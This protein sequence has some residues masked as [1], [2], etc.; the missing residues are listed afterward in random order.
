MSTTPAGT[1]PDRLYDLIPTVYRLRDADEGWP[2]RAL[3]RVLAEQAS[4]LEDDITGLYRNWF[5]ET[6]DAWVLPYIGALVGFA[7]AGGAGA[8][9]ARAEVANTIRLRRRKGTL[10][11]LA[12]IAE[13]V[14]GWPARAVE[15]YRALALAQHLDHLHA[16]R[17]RTVELRNVDA[18]AAIGTAFD[19]TARNVDVRRSNSTH[20]AGVGNIPDVGV[21]LWRLAARTVSRAPAYCYEEESPNC[22]LF[23]ALG[24]DTP[25]FV[26]PK[27][28]GADPPLPVPITR[29]AFERRETDQKRGTIGSGIQHYYGPHGSLMIWLGAPPKPV[30]ADRIVAADLRDW[31]YRPRPGQV[32]VDPERG[33]IM[34]PPNEVRRQPVT[35]SYAAGAVAAIGGG[36]YPR[37]LDAPAGA[38][39]LRVGPEAEFARLTD[40]LAAWRAAAPPAAVIEIQDSGVY[41]EPFAV[42]LQSGQGLQLRAAARV[43]P[44]LRLLDWQ[45]DRPDLLSVAGER[46]SWF[47]LDGMT[48]T[49]RGMEISGDVA[50]VVIRHSTLV[51]GWGLTCLCDP[52]RPAEPSILVLGRPRCLTL[53]HAIIGAIRVERDQAVDEPLLLR[54]QDSVIDA[55]A[56]TR[57]ALGASD[58]LCADARLTLARCTVVGEVQTHMIDLAEDSILDGHVLAC[59]RQVGCVRFCAL[60][61]GSR[62]PR[63]YACTEKAPDF[64]STRYGL[65]AY[66]RLSR[67]C[68]P[69]IGSGAESGSE[70]GVYHDLMQPQRLA[71]VRQ[72]LAEYGPA[73]TSTGVILTT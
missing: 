23:S 48:V 20:A 50:G 14:G 28:G 54:A 65:P 6:C 8:P 41:A 64:D 56:P 2:L 70:M 73:S 38:M 13:A 58:R 47:K 1:G 44:V 45:G 62:T 61:A 40:A 72:R 25:L 43:R 57:A 60:P 19:R 12:A 39:L 55:T 63:R 67:A 49:G 59:R 22:Y 27:A 68:P 69:E 3:L 21:Y 30:P 34:F 51:P 26:D 53:E 32:A 71:A 42:E 15:F 11:A 16:D 66:L 31:R 17:G 46:G 37:P 18:L 5:V 4:L 35:V 29:L 24:N 10:A 36:E 7:P 9:V 33:R 52:R